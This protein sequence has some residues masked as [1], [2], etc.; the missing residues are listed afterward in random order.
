MKELQ[1]IHQGD[2]RRSWLTLGNIPRYTF[3][4][5]LSWCGP[6]FL[7][8]PSG[9]TLGYQT[10]LDWAAATQ[11][12]IRSLLKLLSLIPVIESGASLSQ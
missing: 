6:T 5:I 12:L 4:E 7:G 8:G 10:F 11:E 1:L 3:C 2:R 9:S